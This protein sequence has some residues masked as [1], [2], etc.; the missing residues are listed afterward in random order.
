LHESAY[1]SGQQ[2]TA[3]AESEEKR[4]VRY[5]LGQFNVALIGYLLTLLVILMY[6][7][8]TCHQPNREWLGLEVLTAAITLPIVFSV[9]PPDCG[10]S[11]A[12]RV[13]LHLEQ[14]NFCF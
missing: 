3:F 7:I 12:S 13:F 5:W 2:N 8:F 14:H 6:I 4:E 9:T 11:P 10:F 1:H